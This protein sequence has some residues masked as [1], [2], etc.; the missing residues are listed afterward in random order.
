MQVE[1]VRRAGLRA[2]DGR[3]RDHRISAGGEFADGKALVPFCARPDRFGLPQ[4]GDPFGQLLALR[5][6]A[7]YAE[8]RQGQIDETRANAGHSFFPSIPGRDRVQARG[9]QQRA[10]MRSCR[11]VDPRG[12]ASAAGDGYKR[13]DVCGKKP[14]G[15]GAIWQSWPGKGV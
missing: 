11:A 13:R 5:E 10:F 3:D 15:A 6:E 1:Q 12:D 2:A 4:L 9:P 8:Q 14:I 7:F